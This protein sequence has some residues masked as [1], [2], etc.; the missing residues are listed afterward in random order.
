MM[1]F[2]S[3]IIFSNRMGFTRVSVFNS[4]KDIVVNTHY[5]PL[6]PFYRNKVVVGEYE[7]SPTHIIRIWK[8]HAI[9]GINCSITGGERMIG[10]MDYSV[11]ANKFKIDY[12]YVRDVDS[13]QYD[14]PTDPTKSCEYVKLMISIAEKKARDLGF[15]NI[16][17]DTHQ[18]LKLYKRYYENEGFE[19]TG[20]PASDHRSWLEMTKKIV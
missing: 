4:V 2:N 11:S 9:A 19:M 20:R 16:I 8:N 13:M 5:K 10:A 18:N 17:M 6:L 7:D 14:T 3:K 1:N 15:E 12:I